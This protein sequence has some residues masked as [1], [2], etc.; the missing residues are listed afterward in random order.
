MNK[1]KVKTI[2]KMIQNEGYSVWVDEDQFQDDISK[3]ILKGVHES[4]F[5]LPCFTKAYLRKL[6]DQ[7]DSLDFYVAS[8][9]LAVKNIGAKKM[10]PLIMESDLLDLTKWPQQ[11]SYLRGNPSFDFS[12]LENYET[13]VKNLIG[14]VQ[15]FLL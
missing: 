12:S 14:Y 15:S 3:D 2:V 6:E 4:A 7:H 10:F 5:F 13:A 11:A 8:Y 9:F 1:V